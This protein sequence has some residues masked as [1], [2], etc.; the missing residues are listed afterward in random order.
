MEP[1]ELKVYINGTLE[2]KFQLKGDFTLNNRRMF[3]IMHNEDDNDN[4]NDNHDNF[5]GC[6]IKLSVP[7]D[8][9][10]FYA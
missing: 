3:M 9:K 8:C 6:I 5:E 2:G 4:H 7:S 10:C 1:G